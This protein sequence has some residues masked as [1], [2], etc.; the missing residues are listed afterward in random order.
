MTTVAILV[1]RD[2]LVETFG[3][4]WTQENANTFVAYK[5]KPYMNLH[6]FSYHDFDMHLSPID[7]KTTPVYLQKEFDNLCK[8]QFSKING[9][10]AKLQGI[11]SLEELCECEAGVELLEMLAGK[12]TEKSVFYNTLTRSSY[13]DS[14]TINLIHQTPAKYI[15]IKINL[16]R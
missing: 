10:K 12:L 7:G 16:H 6:L 13:I 2:D 4:S 8:K 11:N 15:L 1:W 14:A 9:V 3:D 5:L